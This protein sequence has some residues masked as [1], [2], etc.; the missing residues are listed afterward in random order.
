[1]EMMMHQHLNQQNNPPNHQHRKGAPLPK[2]DTMAYRCEEL[3]E[4]SVGYSNT[5]IVLILMENFTGFA[6]F[7]SQSSILIG[8]LTNL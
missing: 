6:L 7:V 3:E 8:I 5:A 2:L 4:K 1:M